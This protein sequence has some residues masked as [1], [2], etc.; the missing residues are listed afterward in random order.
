M[1]FKGVVM[2]T[3]DIP[4]NHN[5]GWTYKIGTAGTYAGKVCEVGDLIICVADGTVASDND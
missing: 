5:A 2:G 4:A 3:S 1:V